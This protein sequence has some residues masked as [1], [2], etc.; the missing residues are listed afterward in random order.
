MTQPG[1]TDERIAEIAKSWAHLQ[2][3]REGGFVLFPSS[4]ENAIKQA[5]KEEREA[6]ADWLEQESDNGE[7]IYLV[8]QLR[9][10]DK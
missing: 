5:L 2:C 10:G 1:I 3:E 4:A 7:V 8:G 9:E 6:I